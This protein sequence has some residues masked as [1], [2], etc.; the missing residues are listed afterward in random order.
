MKRIVLFAGLMFA[1]LSAS[2]LTVDADLPAG[3]IVFEKIDGDTVFVHQ[4]LRDTT[5][6]WFYW[7]MR[8]RGAAGRTLTFKFTQSHAVG[9]RG[10]VVSLDRGKTFSYAAEK[11][12]GRKSFVYAFPEDADEVWF[13]QAWPYAPS[14]WDRFLAAHESVRGKW[15][16]S[17]VLCRSRKG[18]E[19]PKARFG[20]LD[21]T[22]RHRVYM[23]SRHHCGETMG[24]MVVEGAA[25]A[26]LADD[27]L[28]RWLR[29]N[30]ELLVVPFVDFD[31][32]VDGDQ[33]KCRAPHD[34]NRD[35][36]AF[37]YPETKAITEW[38][39]N[40]TDNRIDVYLDCHCPWLFGG[41]NDRLYTPWKDPAIVRD[42]GAERRFSNL[43][44]K[45][46]CGSMRYKAD[47]DLPFG[48]GWNNAATY[49]A[50][51]SSEVWA[52][53]TLKGLRIGRT[54]EVPFA[55]ANGATVTPDT[56]RALGRDVAKTIRAL[57][58]PSVREKVVLDTDI[59]ADIDD[60][61]ALLY[62]AKEPKCDL[63]GVTTVGGASHV[64]ASLASAILMNAGRDDVKIYPGVSQPLVDRR[65]SE[66]GVE[67]LRRL[68]KW[69]HATFRPG[70][71]AVDFL[72]KTI[73]ENPGEVTIVA[74]GPFSNLAALFAVDP[75]CAGLLKRVVAMGGYFTGEKPEWNALRDAYATEILIGRNRLHRVRDLTFFGLDVTRQ[76]RLEEDAACAF[77]KSAP[78]F[79]I[80][81]DLS[82]DWLRKFHNA[83]LHDPL[84]A[85]ALFHPEVCAY[86]F[87]DV[88]VVPTGSE[89]GRTTVNGEIAAVPDAA[90]RIR[91]ATKVDR[92]RFYQVFGEIAGDGRVASRLWSGTPF[93]RKADLPRV[94]GVRFSRIKA[95][96]PEKDGFKWLHGVALAWHGNRLYVSYGTNP[97][98][99]NT[100]GERC[101]VRYS[102]DE[103]RTWSE[104]QLVA[105]G[106]ASSHLAV[107]HGSLLSEGGRLYS[108][109]G[110]FTNHME[111]VHTHLAV[112]ESGA[113]GWRDLGVV[114]GN[115]FWPMQA[116]VRMADGN[117][118]M[119]G[120]RVA[121]GVSGAKGDRPA[122][123]IS[124]GGD[125]TRWTVVPVEDG[126]IAKC[127]G[128]ATVDVEGG[129]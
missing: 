8:V 113:T 64:R 1:G 26:F 116:P 31:G 5:T 41:E 94:E 36:Q 63:I 128:E 125:F 118:I 97:G 81:G 50:G 92:D 110:A 25:A 82:G 27:E 16:E 37:L 65:D 101:H 104:P 3:N 42:A 122:V 91:I 47:D 9:M 30:V 84:A 59:G 106:E 77:F 23:C 121:K 67:H 108:F 88:S 53:K 71:V 62:L 60:Q 57:L 102:E 99:E 123:A 34:H 117:W 55:L 70:N 20:R 78:A 35:Y 119:G 7:A 98:V 28:G 61:A 44:E 76:T 114:A 100:A 87:A 72:R 85:V 120:I 126:E 10:P 90:R 127:W 115:G 6:P 21:G 45:L 103:G 38:V 12:A 93:P 66:D 74:V 129:T 107:S 69:P 96:E 40:Q 58:T 13:Y 54:L 52:L 112:L 33:G 46:Q 75:E 86:G 73:R 124:G 2:A 68:K 49:K 80:L 43:L 51:W 48:V 4:D 56:C 83:T 22:A 32:V 105:G 11:G 24:T 15:F 17:S 14:D 109:M 18:R 111:G 19:V 39:K 29:E 89:A 79:E 95:F